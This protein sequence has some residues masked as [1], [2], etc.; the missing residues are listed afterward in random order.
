MGR[1]DHSETTFENRTKGTVTVE[2]SV[3]RVW[4]LRPELL[5]LG[6]VAVWRG[7]P[8]LL[9]HAFHFLQPYFP[10]CLAGVEAD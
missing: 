2:V 9:A 3:G 6:E 8:K 7:L 1:E 5:G 10:H 4:P